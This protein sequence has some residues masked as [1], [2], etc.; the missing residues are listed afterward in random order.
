MLTHRSVQLADALAPAGY[1]ADERASRA[2]CDRARARRRSSTCAP[3]RGRERCHA[4]CPTSPPTQGRTKI[5][6]ALADDPQRPAAQ[7]LGLA[8]VARAAAPLRDQAC[9]PR[10]PVGLQQPEHLTSPSNRAVALVVNRR[11]SR[12]RST[13]SRESSP[14]LISRTVTP[15]TPGYPRAVTSLLSRAPAGQSL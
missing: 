1:E 5:P 6:I 7:P 3:S 2:A 15:N 8:P 11:R 10:G 13:P 9:W 14:S 12:S 4:A